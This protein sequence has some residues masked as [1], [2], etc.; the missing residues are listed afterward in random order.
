[1]YIAGANLSYRCMSHIDVCHHIAKLSLCAQS[2]VNVCQ[3][4]LY[5]LGC[6]ATTCSMCTYM[7]VDEMK[8]LKWMDAK[9]REVR[10]ERN[11]L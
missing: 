8:M 1:M 6:C 7:F 10:I 11:I 2:H 5:R 3:V 4:M 9:I